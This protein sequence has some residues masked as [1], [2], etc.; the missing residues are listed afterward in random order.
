[1]AQNAGSRM[2]VAVSPPA[3]YQ[4]CLVVT[5]DRTR[6]SS[7]ETANP[8]RQPGGS[9]A[10]SRSRGRV[11][12]RPRDGSEF[13]ELASLF[14]ARRGAARR[15]AMKP[16]RYPRQLYVGSQEQRRASLR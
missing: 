4:N 15:G 5:G 1:M 16:E 10:K 2:W 13:I 7:S 6:T 3:A 11:H 14:T 12:L 9:P 8:S